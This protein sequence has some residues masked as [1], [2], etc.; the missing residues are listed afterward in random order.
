MSLPFEAGLET[1]DLMLLD[2]LANPLQVGAEGYD[3]SVTLVYFRIKGSYV[4]IMNHHPSPFGGASRAA[5]A[6]RILSSK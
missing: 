5:R 4:G 3:G 2:R 1:L 6:F